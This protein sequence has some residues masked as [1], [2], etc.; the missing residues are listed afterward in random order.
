MKVYS[1]LLLAAAL[2]YCVTSRHYLIETKD[3]ADDEPLSYEEEMK[4]PAIGNNQK[5]NDYQD[6][7]DDYQD[8][9]GTF[10]S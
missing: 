6:Y 9:Y 2:A 3:D 8:Y 4:E 5:K 7:Q 10:W 1:F